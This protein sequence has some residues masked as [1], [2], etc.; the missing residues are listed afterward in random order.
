[1]ESG[2]DPYLSVMILL[3]IVTAVIFSTSFFSVSELLYPVRI[4]SSYVQ[5]N[6]KEYMAEWSRY[7]TSTLPQPLFMPDQLSLV[8]SPFNIFTND[9]VLLKGWYFDNPPNPLNITLLV[10]HD[11]N[12]GKINY[13]NFA[14]QF[15]ERG[16]R[17]LLIDMRAHGNS[18]G[19][20]F[21]LG[22][23]SQYDV[24]NILDSLYK[25]PET[26]NVVIFG[27]G[28]GAG[29]AVDVAALDYRQQSLIL[30]SPYN[31]MRNYLKSY[32]S[33]KW[34]LL[35]YILY[36]ISSRNLQRHI[37]VKI[38]DIN[39]SEKIKYLA[40]PLMVILGSK[41]ELI[42]PEESKRVYVASPAVNKQILIVK[43]AGHDNIDITEGDAYFNKLS[44]FMVRSLPKQPK[45][46]RF[47]K[48]A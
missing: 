2:K 38:A 7:D 44:I 23:Q 16:I 21:Y 36:P 11:I 19:D 15:W 35:N 46:T 4:D 47:K 10:I 39:L 3:G 32:T 34:G 48:L 14:R 24:L 31:D 12:E 13:I 8:Y 27:K 5:K 37:G 1:M 18:G 25:L 28:I 26:D 33:N 6:T 40:N 30:Q 41:D 9:S 17:V 43:D 20:K 45:K 22:V 42:N 29:I